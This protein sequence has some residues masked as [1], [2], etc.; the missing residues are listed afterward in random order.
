MVNRVLRNN[1]V[2]V[3]AVSASGVDDKFLSTSVHMVVNYRNICW[4][5]F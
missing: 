3:K 4:Y 5:R 1:G 2:P